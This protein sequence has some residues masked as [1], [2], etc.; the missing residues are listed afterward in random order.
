MAISHVSN[1][2]APCV[3]DWTSG[4][5]G[6]IPMQIDPSAAV[7]VKPRAGTYRVAAQP[8]RV[9]L[10]SPRR[11]CGRPSNKTRYPWRSACEFSCR[12]VPD[13]LLSD[14]LWLSYGVHRDNGQLMAPGWSD[15][16]TIELYVAMADSVWRYDP[17]THSLS[18]RLKEDIRALTGVLDGAES[19]PVSLIFSGRADRMTDASDR[20]RGPRAS[21]DAGF[22]QWN[23]R[24]FCASEGLG[25]VVQAAFDG[26]KLARVLR[27][28]RSQVV[29][30]VQTVGYPRHSRGERNGSHA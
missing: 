9:I 16:R 30:S 7:I 22:I 20:E 13:Q 3:A 29:T 8:L 23:V 26:P 5:R 21:A 1:V 17:R 10:P 27:L 11:E 2:C 28:P 19:A 6:V 15:A 25:T 14:L 4:P 12:T 18:R 24:L